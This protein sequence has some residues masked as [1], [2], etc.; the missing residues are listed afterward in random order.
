MESLDSVRTLRSEWTRHCA[1]EC[2]LD[3]DFTLRTLHR[4]LLWPAEP[5]D[6]GAGCYG[7]VLELRLVVGMPVS[8]RR[9]IRRPGEQRHI[10]AAT[11]SIHT[12]RAIRQLSGGEYEVELEGLDIAITPVDTEHWVCQPGEGLPLCLWLRPV[13]FMYAQMAHQGKLLP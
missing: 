3:A 2:A 4:S 1:Y 7:M 12:V 10:I 5:H 8:I 9:N 11:G 6:I 13:N